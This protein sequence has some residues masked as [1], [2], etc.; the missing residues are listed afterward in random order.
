MQ[1]SKL[2]LV[3]L[4]I[5]LI[6]SNSVKASANDVVML[7]CKDQ[8]ISIHKEGLYLLIH[9]FGT[10]LKYQRYNNSNHPV[11]G[12]FDAQKQNQEKTWIFVETEILDKNYEIIYVFAI[13]NLSLKRIV[14]ERGD[15]RAFKKGSRKEPKICFPATNPF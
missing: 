6:L 10:D 15:A 3:M 8:N 7:H 5:S 11:L 12:T 1:T 4:V 9:G 13:N 2:T 14:H